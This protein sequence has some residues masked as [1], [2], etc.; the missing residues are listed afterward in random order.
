[1]PAWFG[2]PSPSPGFG[3]II[4]GRY[5]P[6]AEVQPATP[7]RRGALTQPEP[8]VPSSVVPLP[9]GTPPAV[10]SGPMPIGPAIGTRTE[11]QV[12]AQ[13]AAGVGAPRP[14]QP[15]PAPTTRPRTL[16]IRPGGQAMGGADLGADAPATPN[17]VQEVIAVLKREGSAV[18]L[19]LAE[20]FGPAMVTGAETWIRARA[21]TE[22]ELAQ[23]IA[24]RRALR[25]KASNPPPD[26][27]LEFL[28]ARIAEVRAARAKG[29]TPPQAVGDKPELARHGIP[30]W[31]TYAGLGI[32]AVSL[33]YTLY[34]A[35][36]E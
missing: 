30:P 23:E 4:P 28:E 31:V 33:A 10:P 36:K 25:A 2:Q 6:G 9:I 13:Q 27:P 20:K 14:V 15:L 29:A 19:R 24:R 12:E 35:S 26:L 8:A 5:P 32:A 11:A 17:P 18:G 7:W 34:R 22:E 21:W 1:M 16:A 3:G